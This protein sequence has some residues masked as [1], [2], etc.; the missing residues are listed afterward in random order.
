MTSDDEPRNDP[1]PP[2]NKGPL[3]KALGLFADVRR[4]EAATALLLTLNVF[5]LLSC[6]YLLKT[7]REPLILKEEVTLSFL[8]H[9]IKIGGAEIKSY[10]SA[11]QAAILIPGT[12]VYGRIAQRVGRM[13]LIAFVTLFFTGCIALFFVGGKAHFPHIGIY[14]FLW[15]GIFNMM[16]IA[17]FWSFAADIYPPDQGKR[18][19][20]ILG[21]G[22][23]V[24]AVAGSA[25]A[26]EVYKPLGPFGLMAAAA[27]ILIASLLVTSIVNT[28]EAGAQGKSQTKKE[29]PLGKEGGWQMLVKDKYLML[30]GGLMFV[31]NWVNSSGEY[32]LDRTLLQT[33]QER[34]PAGLDPQA[35]AKWADTFIGEFKADYF[36]YVN[37]ISVGMQLFVVSRVIKYLGVRFALLLV[38]CISFTG[39][40]T[41][42]FYPALTIIFIVK[43]AE[44]SLDYSLQNTSRQ[45]LW[46]VTSRDAKY[47]AKSVIDTFLVR[48]GDFF[49]ALVTLVG[50]WK[51]FTTGTFISINAALVLC[52]IA[53]V[54]F[55]TQKYKERSAEVAAKTGVAP[56]LKLA[57]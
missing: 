14:F 52:W 42:I 47:K 49:S 33:A 53:L 2:S 50:A 1:T 28:R 38:P 25:V 10:S 16:I 5:L 4:G 37:V 27:G 30:I 39:Y 35:A 23:T 21:I 8:G 3:E 44:N 46:L 31:L 13:K 12:Y 22:S 11:G 9:V 32:I 26:R 56:E 15:V 18:L 36:L 48:A 45:A 51:N 7:A 54:W 34:V 24:G 41:M 20:A 40:S 55:L 6:Y 19:F 29:E 43:I 57:S 17:Q